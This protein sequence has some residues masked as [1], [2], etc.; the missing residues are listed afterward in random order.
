MIRY[1][2]NDD[3][4]NSNCDDQ[5]GG[6]SS[7]DEA[8]LND[9]PAGGAILYLCARDAFGQVATWQGNYNWDDVLPTVSAT[10]AT[11]TLNWT[12]QAPEVIISAADTGGS[13]L[14]EVR[15]SLEPLF[16]P[17]P[18]DGACTAGGTIYNQGNLITVSE[19]E[20]SL[21]L[22]AR[23]QAGNVYFWQ[24]D[25]L[26]AQDRLSLNLTNSSSA[27]AQSP[28]AT[29]VTYASGSIVNLTDAAYVFSATEAVV[30]NQGCE[31]LTDSL[32]INSLPSSPA[33]L[34]PPEGESWLHLCL[35]DEAG[36][37]KTLA[38]PFAWEDDSPAIVS[39]NGNAGSWL[40]PPTTTKITVTDSSPS[41]GL[42]QAHYE[43]DDS[44]ILGSDCTGGQSLSLGENT[45]AIPSGI[46]ILYLCAKDN[47]GNSTVTNFSYQYKYAVTVTNN[48]TLGKVFSST[49]AARNG[50]TVTLTF[51]PDSGARLLAVR[52]NAQEI[53]LE[54]D[55]NFDTQTL[56]YTLDSV[57]SDIAVE[58][59]FTSPPPSSDSQSSTPANSSS[60]NPT[61]PV[62]TAGAPGVNPPYIYRAT[63]ATGS[64][65]IVLYFN[66][67]DRPFTHYLLF[68]GYAGHDFDFGFTVTEPEKGQV[69]IGGLSPRTTYQ[70]QLTAMNDCAGGSSSNVFP[71]TLGAPQIITTAKA[72]PLESVPVTVTTLTPSTDTTSSTPVVTSPT[73]AVTSPTSTPVSLAADD[74]RTSSSC[75][76]G[77]INFGLSCFSIF[78]IGLLI[79]VAISLVIYFFIKNVFLKT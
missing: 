69:T 64:D 3:F 49:A 34:S 67:G 76:L 27:W 73:P 32:V 13:S 65:E 47:A 24:G 36:H 43:W 9:T 6:Q 55:P 77:G 70:F 58:G 29:T 60:N 14:M 52:I 37:F 68:Y 16:Y 39:D 71:V 54:S 17:S 42:A 62:C 25:Y 53:D 41:S 20:W 48:H 61:A 10:G 75:Q 35:R 56:T 7:A 72:A 15:G 78:A 19:G 40:A 63:A 18:F 28:L 44:S 8:G 2:W 5:S 33:V 45:L 22:C 23:D 46:H 30:F 79:A 4:A 31:S 1:R 26:Y 50:E 57:S 21:Y 12:S 11:S 51:T 74:S 66:L 59:I 38:A